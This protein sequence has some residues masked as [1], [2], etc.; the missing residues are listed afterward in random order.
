MKQIIIILIAVIFC[1]CTNQNG[2]NDLEGI[3][4]RTNEICT[5]IANVILKDKA[6]MSNI[7]CR[8][9]DD[10]E[11]QKLKISLDSYFYD[12]DEF[13]MEYGTYLIRGINS[14][15]IDSFDSLI[16]KINIVNS[17]DISDTNSF[18]RYRGSKSNIQDLK[19]EYLVINKQYD[20]LISFIVSND[21][22][23]GVDYFDILMSSLN[24]QD[25][26]LNKKPFYN[27]T[28]LN[29]LKNVFYPYLNNQDSS[30]EMVIHEFRS[31]F[32]EGSFYYN[33][34]S[35]LKIVNY[36][37]AQTGSE[38]IFFEISDT[39]KYGVTPDW[40]FEEK[41]HSQNPSDE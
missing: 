33:K 4:S 2:A 40:I 38:G 39:T 5:K 35:A 12:H 23:D 8:A 19:N 37:L 30:S 34:V 14:D 31:I 16:L 10:N 11:C 3:K 28:F 21:L 20:S 22:I 6:Q 17:K 15:L 27:G 29:Y 9:F 36:I 25:K 7:Q 1:S 26:R 32:G 13:L 24:E 41:R 18:K